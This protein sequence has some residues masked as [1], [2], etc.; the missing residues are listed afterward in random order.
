MKD[1]D[2]TYWSFK[3]SIHLYLTLLLFYPF[4]SHLGSQVFW[5]R[6]RVVLTPE[7]RSQYLNHHHHKHVFIV[8]NRSHS[9]KTKTKQNKTKNVFEGSGMVK[10]KGQMNQ[11]TLPGWKRT[12]TKQQNE[13]WIPRSLQLAV[14]LLVVHSSYGGST[15]SFDH[16]LKHALNS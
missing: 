13:V 5:L 9:S 2:L 1:V 15:M 14:F 4:R 3:H 12:G 16:N 10:A 7:S 6:S 11:F 8:A